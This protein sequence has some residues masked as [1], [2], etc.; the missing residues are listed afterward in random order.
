[1]FILHIIQARFGDSLLLEFGNG[2]SKFILIDGGPSGVFDA[3]LRNEL[4][5]IV[6]T[7]GKL[8]TL[9]VS[10]VDTD[11][12]NGV[13][14]LLAELKS[15]LDSG[16]NS[17]I[18]IKSFWLNSF[19]ETID[20][21]GT[22]SQ[23]VN[24][25]LSHAA[26]AGINMTS[27]SVAV[28]GIKEGHRLTTFCN[29]LGIPLN[30]DAPKGIFRVGSPT[31]PIQMENISIT[32]VGP[33]TENLDALKLEWQEWLD[34]RQRDLD[35]NNFSLLSMSDKSVPN[36]SSIMFIIEAEDK[37]ILFTGDGRGDHLLTGLKKKGFLKDGRCHVDVLK[38]AH[39]GSDRN[40][41]R[42]F[43]ETVTAD[44]YVISADGKHGNPDSATLGWI[45]E[46]AKDQG[47]PIKLMITNETPTTNKL[48]E[49]FPPQQFGYEIEFIKPGNNSMR[50][51][52]A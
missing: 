21:N 18:S 8:E 32:I 38:V 48:L 36:L 45:V 27:T 52:L 28:N 22:I 34:N 2:T 42:G 26:S 35:N 19:S 16:N 47:R 25:L 51:K 17:F 7:N 24:G 14:D 11:H 9:V 30:Q 37:T 31:N 10:H 13:L 44:T 6:G 1:M 4:E 43:F 15:D 29:V 39:H 3:H 20:T 40:T 5:R 46:A 49:D 33:T 50:L 12:T 41:T 23:Q